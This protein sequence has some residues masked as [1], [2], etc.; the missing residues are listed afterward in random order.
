MRQTSLRWIRCPSEPS[1]LFGQSRR[2]WSSAPQIQHGSNW[3]PPPPRLE[4]NAPRPPR[5]P[6]NAPRP[7]SPNP[8]RPPPN[9]PRPPL[10]NP[11]RPPNAP[12]PPS[13][14]PPRPPPNAPRPPRPPPNAPRPP[15]NECPAPPPRP[16]EPLNPPP[17]RVA[18]GEAPRWIATVSPSPRKTMA[19]GFAAASSRRRLLIFVLTQPQAKEAQIPMG[20]Q[21]SGNLA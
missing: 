15:S 13:P 9:A 21:S 19:S 7:L 8:P 17:P 20:P 3:P 16:K 4:P 10:P 1:S 6:P 2:R 11:P 5:P 14:N 12:R 18:P